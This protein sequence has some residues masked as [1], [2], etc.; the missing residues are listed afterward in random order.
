MDL[1]FSRIYTVI[2]S[3]VVLRLYCLSAGCGLKEY[4]SEETQLLDPIDNLFD[5]HPAEHS[6][7]LC[8][9]SH[10]LPDSDPPLFGVWRG[11]LFLL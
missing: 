9:I 2:D 5:P 1:E 10:T 6:L 4:D 8:H 11:L 7:V 3:L